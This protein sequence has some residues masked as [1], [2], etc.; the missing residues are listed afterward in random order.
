MV[1][2][3][4]A[5]RGTATKVGGGAAALGIDLEPQITSPLCVSTH[6]HL[7]PSRGCA[8]VLHCVRHGATEM[9]AYL[10][11]HKYGSPHQE[12]LRDPML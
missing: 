5:G 1:C 4:A 8:Q 10:A 12:P 7:Q 2:C 9:T 11:L 6:T 3:A